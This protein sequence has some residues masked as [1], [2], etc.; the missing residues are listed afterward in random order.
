V[1]RI[2]STLIPSLAFLLAVYL[3]VAA[4]ADRNAPNERIYVTGLGKK[5]F[6]SDLIVWEGSF[7]RQERE[8]KSAYAALARDQNTVKTYLVE[9]GLEE[10]EILFSS[11]DI[12]KEFDYSYT[13]QGNRISTFVGYRLSQRVEIESQAVEKVEQI[14]RQITELINRGVEFYSFA[15]QYYYTQ[16]SQ[17]KLEMIAAATEDA[18]QRAAGIADKAGAELGELK[19]ARMGIFQIIG[20]HSNED[21]SWGGTFNTADKMKTATIT[22][23][24]EF[25]LD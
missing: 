15:P 5:D 25:G 8:L 20:Q 18:T 6:V 3:G 2:I 19:Q 13:P 24:L 12:S 9:M 1:K 22:M 14:S 7:S 16:L 10:E 4:Y 17:L 23:R 11:V 21:Y